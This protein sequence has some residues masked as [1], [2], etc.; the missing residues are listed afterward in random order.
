M[1][2]AVLAALQRDCSCLEAA[3]SVVER[4]VRH[5]EAITAACSSCKLDLVDE[6]ELNS[7]FR[8]L[9]R[10][11]LSVVDDAMVLFTGK[12]CRSYHKAA[13]ERLYRGAGGV[14]ESAL[15]SRG[16]ESAYFKHSEEFSRCSVDGLNYECRQADKN[17]K[18]S[19]YED[20][21]CCTF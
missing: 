12:L 10:L 14:T 17:A 13:H 5:F 11:Y 21:C 16:K 2:K 20:V 7:F 19:K 9:F 6:K 4:A 8:R 15:H 18:M 1:S 3:V